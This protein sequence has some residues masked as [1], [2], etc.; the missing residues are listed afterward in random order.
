MKKI[1]SKIKKILLSISVFIST[2]ISK[3][4]AVQTNFEV[5]NLYGA[6][7]KEP[8]KEVVK[9]VFKFSE[10]SPV[11]KTM[12]L[13]LILVLGFGVFVSKLK[14]KVKTIIMILLAVVLGIFVYLFRMK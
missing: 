14:K 11:I 1:I 7:P 13:V 2:T 9:S 8:E 3:V 4:Y 6:I 10:M 5:V 12:S